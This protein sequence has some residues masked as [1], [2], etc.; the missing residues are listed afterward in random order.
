MQFQQINQIDNKE[1]IS[2]CHC[3]DC[4]GGINK[5]ILISKREYIQINSKSKRF[6]ASPQ[7]SIQPQHV[8]PSNRDLSLFGS[9][10]HY[11]ISQYNFYVIN[12]PNR[13]FR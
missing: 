10:A 4:G 3:L 5:K 6:P 11:N 2:I 9:P 8:R 13:L 1:L 7:L 12:I